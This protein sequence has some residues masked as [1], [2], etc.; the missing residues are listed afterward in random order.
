MISANLHWAL[1]MTEATHFPALALKKHQ[2]FMSG[3]GFH[4]PA[5]IFNGL[6]LFYQGSLLQ[7]G[8]KS[9]S[10]YR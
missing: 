8:Q 6:K 2:I 9:G 10:C 1:L 5:N 3:S 4:I 7:F